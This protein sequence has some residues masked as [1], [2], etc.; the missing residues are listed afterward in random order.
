MNTYSQ[1]LA[2]VDFSEM[3]GMVAARALQLAHQHGAALT[4]LHVVQDI[5]AGGEPFSEGSIV[6]N[7]ET[8][9]RQLKNAHDK[10]ARLLEELDTETREAT[11]IH[12]VV[13]EGLPKDDLTTYAENQDIDLIVIGHSGKKGFLGMMGSTAESVVHK[14]KCDVFV[15]RDGG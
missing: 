4:L 1:I 11:T 3:S 12:E 8:R 13:S 7:T 9:D 2:P 5:P 15:V 14:A 6:V 10:L